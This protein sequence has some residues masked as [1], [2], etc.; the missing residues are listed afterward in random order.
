MEEFLGREEHDRGIKEVLER[1]IGRRVIIVL[2]HG[3]RLFVRIEAVRDG[4]LI[5][6]CDCKV[7]FID[8]E[9]ICAVITECPEVL[10]VFLRED[11]EDRV[12]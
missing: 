8:I 12:C 11:R 3:R 1:L 7:I 5:A 10:R 4:L 9:C 2:E 6:A